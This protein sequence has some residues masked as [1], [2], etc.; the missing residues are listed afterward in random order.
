V[1]F[2]PQAHIVGGLLMGAIGVDAVR[3][4]RRPGGEIAASPGPVLNPP[5]PG[6][7]DSFPP[8]DRHRHEAGG[9]S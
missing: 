5:G 9:G 4:I 2:S 6:L 8:A 1:C 3:H 7:A